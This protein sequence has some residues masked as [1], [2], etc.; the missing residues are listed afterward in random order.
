MMESNFVYC[1]NSTCLSC[2]CVDAQ[3]YFP[4]AYHRFGIPYH[5]QDLVGAMKELTVC[6][7]ISCQ[8]YQSIYSL[9]KI[10]RNCV[11]KYFAAPSS[12]LS[13]VWASLENV[14]V[15]CRRDYCKMDT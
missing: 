1:P 13:M 11:G 9:E 15:F 5:L 2:A 10:R 7:I 4:P 12:K 6:I 8:Q 14:D 3:S